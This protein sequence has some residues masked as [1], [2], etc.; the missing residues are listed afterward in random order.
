VNPWILG[1]GHRGSRPN[2]ARHHPVPSVPAGG[3]F[4]SAMVNGSPREEQSKIDQSPDVAS[5][6]SRRSTG[7]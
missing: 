2:V 1:S 5:D 3:R 7:S 4:V 6:S